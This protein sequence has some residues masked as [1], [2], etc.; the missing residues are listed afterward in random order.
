MKSSQARI[1]TF[2]ASLCWITQHNPLVKEIM[3][4]MHPRNHNR[5]ISQ[6][7]SPCWILCRFWIDIDLTHN[8]ALFPNY[9]QM[10]NDAP[11]QGGSKLW[12]TF[13]L[14][15]SWQNDTSEPTAETIAFEVME[16]VSLQIVSV[17]ISHAK[18]KRRGPLKVWVL[19][20]N[21]L[22]RSNQS[23]RQWTTMIRPHCDL[24]EP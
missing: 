10:Y 2:I 5:T 6:E 1:Y 16:Q 9:S 23:I 8:G 4:H 19:L 3:I 24:K 21:A 20:R 12:N 18:S 14:L 22:S 17:A 13:K 15:F 11:H 7:T